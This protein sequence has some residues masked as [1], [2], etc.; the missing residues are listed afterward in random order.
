MLVDCLGIGKRRG[1]ERAKGKKH[2]GLHCFGDG[3]F[4][5]LKG[6]VALG[7]GVE[8]CFLLLK[9]SDAYILWLDKGVKSIALRTLSAMVSTSLVVKLSV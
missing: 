5:A 9:Q 3:G 2:T 7:V 8:H 4:H 6:G 1:V